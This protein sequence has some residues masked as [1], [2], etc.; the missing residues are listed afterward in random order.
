[1]SML[2]VCLRICMSGCK[3]FE[4]HLE[5]LSI[6]QTSYLNT[7]A[8]ML[9]TLEDGRIDVYCDAPSV[10]ALSSWFGCMRDWAACHWRGQEESLPMVCKF[11]C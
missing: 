4:Q 9:M 7:R 8:S 1:M 6:I 2:G 10:A 11:A 5:G 3:P